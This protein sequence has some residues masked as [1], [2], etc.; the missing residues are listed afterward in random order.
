VPRKPIGSQL[1]SNLACSTGNSQVR[2]VGRPKLLRRNEPSRS[3]TMPCAPIQLAWRQPLA[4]SQRPLTRY[5]PGTAIPR[6][7]FGGP[8]AQVAPASPNTVRA[9]FGSR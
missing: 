9:A 3:T 8:Q 5:P 6:Q 7:S 4:K 2:I 1:S